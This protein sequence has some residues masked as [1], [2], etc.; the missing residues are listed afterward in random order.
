[1]KAEVAAWCEKEALFSRGDN[2]LCAVS[3]GAD[4][5]AM[6]WCLYVLREELC[7][8][9]AA[10]HFNH[11]LRGAEADR[12]EAFV[13]AFCQ[14]HGI[15]L[16]VG[17]AEVAQYAAE[18]A[19]GIEE[20]ARECRYAFLRSCACD[21]LATAHTADDNAET[22][23]LHLLR[24]S[25]L[26]GLCGIPPKRG[27]LV[28]PLLSVTRGQIVAFLQAEGIT[29]VEDSTN[30]GEICMRNRLR[31]GVMPSL[32]AMM[33][34]LSERL[35]VQS[36]LLR[37]EDQYLDELASALLWE[38]NG[39]Y[40]CAPLRA[41]PEVLQRRALRLMTRGVL[42]QDVSFAHIAALQ[43]ILTSPNPSAQCALPHGY[44]ARR[45]YDGIELVRDTA[46]TFPET[47]LQ[48]PGETF[49][50]GLGAKITCEITENFKKSVNSPFRF[51]VK[52]DMITQSILWIR[53]RRGGDQMSV[54]GVHR[55]TL[56]KLF[57]ERRIPRAERE[58][59]AVLTDGER[60]LAV[61]GIGTD[62]RFLPAEGEPAAIIQISFS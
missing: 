61:A 46:T 2:V 6:L 38:E 23:L 48:I 40:A 49:L 19:M 31:H 53:P 43:G 11:H 30:A 56:K 4:S 9:V 1:M 25:G 8:T 21:K 44:I 54:D 59:T 16:W 26:R 3:G 60:V 62:P 29:W 10:A 39:V 37:E 57:I 55:K 14:A 17:G 42:A 18:H 35:T 58:R 24:G 45:R 33:P 51:A 13:K 7:I 47:A 20:A 41:A 32:H 27:K 36:R 15:P 5:M 52:Y 22:V 50:P 34:R 28:R 12:D